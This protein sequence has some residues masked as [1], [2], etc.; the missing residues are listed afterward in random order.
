MTVVRTALIPASFMSHETT[1]QQ[2][3]AIVAHCDANGTVHDTWHLIESLACN[4]MCIVSLV[5]VL[6]S[7]DGAIWD[8]DVTVVNVGQVVKQVGIHEVV[9]AL[10]IVRMQATVLVLQ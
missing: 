2:E 8:V 4:P 10:Q 7:R 1:L 5:D 9:I 3:V 6:G